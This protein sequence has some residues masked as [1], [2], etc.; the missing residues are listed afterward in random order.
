VVEAGPNRNG[1][2][3]ATASLAELAALLLGVPVRWALD[4]DRDLVHP[5]RGHDPESEQFRVGAIESAQARP[6]TVNAIVKLDPECGRLQAAL[7][8]MYMRGVLRWQL[9]LSLVADVV[10]EQESP[11]RAPVITRWL[12]VKAVDIVRVPASGAARF[13][14]PAEP[15]EQCGPQEAGR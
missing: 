5:P 9:G 7:D 8:K 14:R 1:E 11:Q 15:G 3:I 4:R 10:R 2:V 12:R 13:H 6:W